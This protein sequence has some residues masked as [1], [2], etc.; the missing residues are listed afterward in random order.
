MRLKRCVGAALAAATVATAGPATA[1]E[2]RTSGFPIDPAL[3]G[4]QVVWADRSTDATAVTVKSATPGAP[5]RAVHSVRVEGPASTRRLMPALSASPSRVLFSSHAYDFQAFGVVPLYAE[6][7]LGPPS[8]PLERI[9]RCPGEATAFRSADVSGDAYAYR[10]CDDGAGHVEI[11]DASGAPASPPRSVG[12][13]GYGARIAG[14]YVAWLD[15]PFGTDGRV[16]EA[17]IVVF[18]R[19]A[20]SELYRVPKAEVPGQIHALDVQDDGKVAF[21]FDPDAAASGERVRVAWASPQEPRVHVLPLDAMDSYDVRIHGDTI[22]FQRGRRAV[23]VVPRAEIGVTDL[24]GDVRIVARGADAEP[25]QGAFDYDGTRL[26]WRALGCG[27]WR[28]IVHAAVD[29]A[30]KP[31]RGRC[32]LRFRA[33]PSLSASRVKLPIGCAPFS[34]SCYASVALRTAERGPDRFVGSALS[35]SSTV[36]VRLSKGAL[37]SLAARGSLRLTAIATVRDNRG[38]SQTRETTFRLRG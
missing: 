9:I 10:Q 23:A 17:D 2:I 1:A 22:A 24:A 12:N 14:R 20:G 7:Y 28:L 37:R 38:R 19:V 21:A 8:G 26:V 35:Q 32:P 34:S 29:P 16:N 27:R 33:R 3:S 31:D 18:D 5:A 30:R 4:E 11:R 6:R 25:F 36:R 15:G 13:G